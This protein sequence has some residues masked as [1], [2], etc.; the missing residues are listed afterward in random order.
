MYAVLADVH[1]A[2]NL[3]RLMA[4][5]GLTYE[6]VVLATG[7]DERTIRGLLRRS[8]RP[9]A[10]TLH[11]LA[12][13]LG[14]PVDE[15]FV[16]PARSQFDRDC[17]PVLES[18]VQSHPEV[19]VDWT[20]EDFDELASR[21]GT[22]GQLTESGALTAAEAM[23]EKRELLDKAAVILETHERELLAEL[24]ELL[25]RRVVVER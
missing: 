6:D 3:R 13:G 21:F 23:N 14:V 12:A 11:K 19:F 22:G 10:R 2:D 20:T 15:L 5:E 9:H 18:V 1:V 24:V 25:Y 16:P 7:L 17:N 8:N 4:R